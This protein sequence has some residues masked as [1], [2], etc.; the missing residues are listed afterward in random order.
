MEYCMDGWYCLGKSQSIPAAPC[1]GSATHSLH[2]VSEDTQQRVL[3]VRLNV[4]GWRGLWIRACCTVRD[5]FGNTVSS[6]FVPEKP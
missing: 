1:G 4:L 3:V 5:S 2:L 6:F